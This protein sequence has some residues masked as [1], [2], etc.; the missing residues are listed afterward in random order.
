MLAQLLSLVEREK[1]EVTR[2]VM[3]ELLTYDTAFGILDF[4]FGR[5]RPF[6]QFQF[7][8]L[9]TLNVINHKI[10][11][12]CQNER[13][14]NDQVQ[15]FLELVYPVVE[16]PQARHAEGYDPGDEHHQNSRGHGEYNRIEVASRLQRRHR[17]QHTE[18]K[19]AADGTK[20]QREQQPQ[21]ERSETAPQTLAA[22]R[23]SETELAER[24]LTAQQQEYPIDDQ[25]RSENVPAIVADE[26]LNKKRAGPFLQN[27]NTDQSQHRIGYDAPQSI[28]QSVCEHTPAAAHIP[29]DVSEDHD[30]GRESTGTHRCQYTQQ[31]RRENRQIAIIRC[32]IFTSLI[33]S[34]YSF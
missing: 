33:I 9:D 4:F 23:S 18:I 20:G 16:S 25:R 11:N 8:H 10:I 30:V 5:K 24:E 34:D 31:E 19:Y 13:D 27:G 1:R 2:P 32:S 21:H 26:A 22:L 3:D 14:R 12:P 28:E 17:Q 29:A 6:H 7:F 15:P